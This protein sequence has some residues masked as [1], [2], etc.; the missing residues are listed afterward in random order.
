MHKRKLQ[1]WIPVFLSL[2]M[3]VGMYL[4]Y[5]MHS[6]MPA[7]SF[8]Y[9]ERSKP[10]QEILD[11]IRAKYVDDVETDALADTAI[12]AIL[13][14]LDPHSHYIPA[15]SVEKANEEIAGSFYGIGIEFNLFDDTLHVINVLKDG[16]G[17]KAG[18]QVGD[19]FL[20]AG[21]TAI[22]GKKMDG[23]DIRNILKGNKG[24]ALKI[25]ILRERKKINIV[26]SRGLIPVTSIDAAYMADSTIG[27][28]RINKFSQQTY[29]EFMQSLEKL[30]KAG[31][32]KLIVDL[33]GN[34]GGVLDEAVEIADEFLEG[35]R[36][37]T[38]T[39]G[40][41]FPR[42]EYRSRRQG[43]FEK[44]PL[45]ILADEGSASASEILIGALQ[46]WDRATVVGRRTFGKGLVQEQFNL[47]DKS[48]VRLTVS[49][50]YTPLGR[51][52]QRSYSAGNK[53]YY[54]M[55]K[56]YTS[57][58]SLQPDSLILTGKKFKTRLGKMVYEGI[59]ITPDIFTASDTAKFGKTTGKV[60]SKGLINNFGYRYVTDN[61]ASLSI[62]KT[63]ADFAGSF[64]LNEEGWKY[65][66]KMAL[67]DSIDLKYLRSD[68]KAF[69]IKSLKLSVARQMWRHEGFYMVFNKEDEG[70]IKALQLLSKQ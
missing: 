10:V 7:K 16:P 23:D 48:A 11:L 44:G 33:R 25:T 27:Y 21:N 57:R 26:V 34:G 61:K 9:R 3:V 45:V 67:K 30:K 2:S 55:S 51:S 40:K 52:I 43:Q 64:T 14:K 62:Y 46:D 39:E 32:K 70:V 56:R 60:Y 4:G 58:D 68:E 24:S 35:D 20:E 50:Y 29:K 8:F 15:K 65:F 17:F 37:I 18:L 6:A 66:E 42:K 22:A 63:P 36:L 47:S 5:K 54:D 38:Y 53:D 28:I 49:R 1:I 59:G 19:K 31:L 13:A 41:H 12:S 69:L